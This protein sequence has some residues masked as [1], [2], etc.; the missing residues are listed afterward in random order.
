VVALPAWPCP[1]A[2]PLYAGRVKAVAGT[3]SSV[4]AC[5]ARTTGRRNVSHVPAW[6][7]AG[8]VGGMVAWQVRCGSGRQ[9]CGEQN[10]GGRVQCGG[11]CG[12]W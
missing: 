2:R 7:V 6:Q 3:R 9:V 1:P 8:A 11:R 10:A 12:R 4:V 5:V